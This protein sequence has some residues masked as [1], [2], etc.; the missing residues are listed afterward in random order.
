MRGCGVRKLLA[1]GAVVAL[2][3]CATTY[4]ESAETDTPDASPPGADGAADGARDARTGDGSVD[5]ADTGSPVDAAEGGTPTYTEVCPPCSDQTTCIAAGC[6]DPNAVHN[7]CNRP[8]DVTAEMSVVAFVCREGPT[9]DFPQA[10]VPGGGTKD[11]RVAAFRMGV[12]L[13]GAA[14]KVQVRGSNAFVAVGDCGGLAT[15]CA[16][17]TNG[18]SQARSVPSGQTALIGTTNALTTC[19]QLLVSFDR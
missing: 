7:A 1:L 11:L 3:A 12:L 8:F 17:G 2:V 4:G 19:Q 14:W 18:P 5:P 6:N 10:C 15:S 13:A 16:G 9:V